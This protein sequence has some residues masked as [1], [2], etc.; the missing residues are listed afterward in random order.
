V[1][2]VVDEV[3]LEYIFI[4]VLWFFPV[5]I[6]ALM[7][8]GQLFIC[9]W[10]YN[11]SSWMCHKVTHFKKRKAGR[12]KCGNVQHWTTTHKICVP[13][14]NRMSVSEVRDLV[15]C[16]IVII[17]II[18]I[19]QSTGKILQEQHCSSPGTPV[20]RFCMILTS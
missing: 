10:H 14:G 5:S 7:F 17:V 19:K 18:T 15:K 13:K 4:N 11:I 2:F 20:L 1:V 3:V 9:H 12:W 6:I 8:H 16:K